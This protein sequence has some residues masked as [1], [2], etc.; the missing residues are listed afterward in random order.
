MAFWSGIAAAP[1]IEQNAPAMTDPNRFQLRVTAYTPS[2]IPMARLA[3]YMQELAALMGSKS[4]VH[5]RGA[6]KGSTILNVEVQHEDIPKVAARLRSASES[7][8]IPPPD[9]VRKAK[10][11]LEALMRTDNARGTLSFGGERII[12][13]LG[14]DAVIAER[15]GP[16]HEATTVEGQVTRVGGTDKTLHALL[17]DD[18]GTT[19]RLTTRSRDKDRN[20]MGKWE[21]AE[22]HLETFEPVPTRT[23]VEAVSE[24]R[25]VEG[26]GWSSM[27]DPLATARALRKH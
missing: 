26:S 10:D 11:A 4:S 6:T 7:N 1:P 12:M 22:L 5:Y 9:D 14:V 19:L 27:P 2:T 15:I 20:E 23:L 3:E 13:F 18:D 17:L 21:L 25:A 8:A 24:L 16:I